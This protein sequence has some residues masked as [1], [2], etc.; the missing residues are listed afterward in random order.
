M[1]QTR[2]PDIR[3]LAARILLA[4][5]AVTIALAVLCYGLWGARHGASALAGGAILLAAPDLGSAPRPTNPEPVAL[6]FWL[7]P[8]LLVAAAACVGLLGYGER[9]ALQRRVE[10]E[11]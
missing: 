2:E 10:R 8:L 3:R 11:L 6:G 4:Q 5:V 9:G 7:A 1:V